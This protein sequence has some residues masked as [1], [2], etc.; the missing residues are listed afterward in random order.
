ME[1]MAG[2]SLSDVEEKFGGALEEKV[3]KLYTRELLLGIKYLH[4]NGF[5]H[6][7]LKSKNVLLGSSGDI[8]LTDFGGAKRLEEFMGNRGLAAR[9]RLSMGGTPL[10]M[11]PE[12][13]RNEGLDFASDIWSLGCTV[14]EM[15]T[16]RPP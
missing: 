13:L 1:Y 10:W 2:D 16:G 8:K 6:C 11:A 15:A 3:I 7:D 9:S 5:V 4:E 14:I 12:V